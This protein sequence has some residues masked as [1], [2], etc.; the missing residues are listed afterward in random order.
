MS[1]SRTTTTS[2]KTPRWAAL[3]I[4]NY[5]KNISGQVQT[6][7]AQKNRS[8]NGL[9]RGKI[10]MLKKL[11]AQKSAQLVFEL[12]MLFSVLVPLYVHRWLS[13]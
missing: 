4:Q 12:I 5:K 3:V 7:D 10:V 1:I 2:I 11:R 13:V 8:E 6:V 9:Y